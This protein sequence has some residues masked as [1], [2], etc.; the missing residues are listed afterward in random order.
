MSLFAK[1]AGHRIK[2]AT[3]QEIMEYA[4]TRAAAEN[5]GTTAGAISGNIDLGA[6]TGAG[7]S[8]D[9][10]STNAIEK[11][12]EL[13]QVLD[14]QNIPQEGRWV[15]LPAW[16]VALL[17]LGDL[18]RADITGD[19][20]GVIRNGLI[21]QVDRMKVYQ[22]NNLHTAV[23]GDTATSTYVLAG[24]KEAMTFASQIDK[25]DQLP[26]PDSFGVYWRT[27]FVYGRAVVQP[28]ALAVLICKKG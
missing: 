27:L 22:S 24:T 10:T 12:V 17:K 20:T 11:L 1:D 7:A 9:I 28:Q 25:V 15:I 4:S 14:E 5:M 23:D 6:I 3:D 26:I 2:I 19:T 13:N 16:Y 18:R 21:G 8:E